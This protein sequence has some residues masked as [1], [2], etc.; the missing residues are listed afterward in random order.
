MNRIC[1]SVYLSILIVQTQNNN[2]TNDEKEQSKNIEPSKT[3]SLFLSNICRNKC[4][5]KFCTER[6]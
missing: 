4:E 5:T 2:Q 6:N 1:H 3:V